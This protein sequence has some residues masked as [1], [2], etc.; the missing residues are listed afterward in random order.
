MPLHQVA[1]KEDSSPKA[2]GALSSVSATFRALVST[3]VPE[4]VALDTRSWFDLESLVDDTLRNRPTS[5][6]RQLRLLLRVIEWAPVVRYGRPF[7]VLDAPRRR[8]VLCYLQ[9]H[10]LQ[11]IRTGFWGLRTLAFLGYYGRPEAARDVGYGAD[12]RGW[13]ALS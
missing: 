12:C 10:R 2:G 7:T 6:Q 3:I 1:E 13:D 5:L 9:D 4:A 11:L 8:K